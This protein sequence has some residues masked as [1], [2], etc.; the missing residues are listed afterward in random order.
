MSID[1]AASYARCEQ[2]TKAH[3]T[4]Y[5]W[6][7]RLLSRDRRPHVYALYAFCRYADDIVDD[8]G[9]A[10]VATRSA[11]LRQLGDRLFADLAVGRSEHE[12]LAALVDTTKRF[13]IDPSCYE[14]FLRSMTMDLTV[15]SYERYDDLVDY[16]EGSAA[17]I[18]EMML[19]ILEPGDPAARAPAR[20]LGIAFQLT[21]FL[22][23]V[24]ED[25]DRGRVYIPQEDLDRFAVDPRDRRVDGSW[26]ALMEFEITRTRA[27][28]RA[29]DEGIP[30]LPVRSAR[31]IR[32]A[33]VL[34]AGIL[35]EIEAN[36]YDVFTRRARVSTVRKLAT[37]AGAFAR[38]GP[39][40]SARST[41]VRSSAGTTGTKKP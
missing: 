27:L 19:P 14:R 1:L 34:Y 13:A 9:D 10:P 20:D 28:Y 40:R 8:L 17:V 41:R 33:R 18:G 26:R 38:P 37:V 24:G 5:Y 4:T 25:L 23:D 15:A 36:D 16:M 31:S 2:L 7:T 21:N 3:G 11:A 30:M 22:R 29:A 12:V 32:S 35:D 6:S 39:S